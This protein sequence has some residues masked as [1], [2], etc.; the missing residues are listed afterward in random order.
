[1]SLDKMNIKE[2]V[3]VH[4]RYPSNA[5]VTMSTATPECV[6]DSDRTTLLCYVNWDAVEKQ[7][8]DQHGSPWMQYTLDHLHLDDTTRETYGDACWHCQDEMF[9]GWMSIDNTHIRV[10]NECAIDASRLTHFTVSQ[11]KEVHLTAKYGNVRIDF[12]FFADVG[13]AERFIH[14]KLGR[15]NAVL[16]ELAGSK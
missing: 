7:A 1:M 16:V 3:P 8:I 5:P 12:G 10:C 11:Y 6:V 14:G 9:S 15:K 4:V 2:S 13:E